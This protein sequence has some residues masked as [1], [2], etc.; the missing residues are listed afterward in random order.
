MGAI[1]GPLTVAESGRTNADSYARLRAALGC[2]CGGY[3]T[4]ES[5]SLYDGLL[6]LAGHAER[7]RS[8]GA[9]T[10]EPQA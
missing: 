1:L 9:W 2:D 10:H 7:L 3:A 5:V 8:A 6:H 4:A